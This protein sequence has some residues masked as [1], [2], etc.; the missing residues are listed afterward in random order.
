M[1]RENEAPAE[2]DV[3][4]SCTKL[5]SITCIRLGRPWGRGFTFRV[6]RCRWLVQSS[7]VLPP[8]LARQEPRSPVTLGDDNELYLGSVLERE[9]EAP[10]E[11]D[12]PAS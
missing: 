2:H 7:Q 11:H 3:P 6:V 10:A 4:A 1:E 5:S 8:R 12:F 9:N